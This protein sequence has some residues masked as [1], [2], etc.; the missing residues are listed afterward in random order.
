MLKNWSKKSLKT[1]KKSTLKPINKK[2]HENEKKNEKLAVTTNV[3]PSDLNYD[4]Y[5]TNKYDIDIIN[6]IPHHKELHQNLINY[7][8]N[9]F[10]K[11]DE[12]RVLD[13]WV[14]TW[15][16]TK[17]IQDILPNAILDVV[18][19]SKQMLNWAKN[20]LWKHN[21]NYILWDY[22]TLNLKNKYDIIVSVIWVHHQNHEWKRS[23]FKKTYNRLNK[24]WVFLFW[25]LVTYKNKVESAY[26][27][28]LHF[29]HLVEK[30]KDKKTLW[31]RAHH[32][33]FLNDLAPYE[34]QIE[35]LKKIWFKIKKDFLKI[36]TCLLIAKK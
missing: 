12:I 24:W 29:H 15:L 4:H 30:S 28:A 10:K 2:T 7:V 5:T 36:N 23:L 9:N 31:E 27:H 16:T 35:W 32:H 34:D 20:R 25:D 13:L 18:D 1:E 3:K 8:K 26:N 33:M 6:S 19:F 22:A 11:A 17:M 14:G 21:V